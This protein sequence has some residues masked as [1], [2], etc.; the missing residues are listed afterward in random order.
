MNATF[1]LFAK[2]SVAGDDQAPL[3]HYLTSHSNK[4]IAGKIPWNF[5]KFLVSRDGKVLA[6]FAPPVSP[7][8]KKVTTL[9]EKALAASK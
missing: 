1:D 5:T 4:D 9:I 8:G 6:K 3:Y 2:V 7:T